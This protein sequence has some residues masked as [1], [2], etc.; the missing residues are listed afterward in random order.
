MNVYEQ[1]YKIVDQIPQGMVMSYGQ[2]AQM[3]PKC[4]ARMVGY[5]LS[6]LPKERDTPWWRVVNSKLQISLR[7]AGEH[8]ILQRKL[9]QEEGILFSP[10]GKIDKKHHFKF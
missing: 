8:H 7:N 6:T 5:G 4:T 10:S 1:M 3:L 9:L 2:I